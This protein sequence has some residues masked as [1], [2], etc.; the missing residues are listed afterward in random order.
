M[1][2]SYSEGFGLAMVEAALAQKKSIVVLELLPSLHE[3]FS[4]N[5]VCFLS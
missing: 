1:M 5:E 4:E 3:I 2:P